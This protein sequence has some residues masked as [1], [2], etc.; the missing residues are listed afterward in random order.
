VGSDVEE[1][2]M[3]DHNLRSSKTFQ[4]AVLILS[5]RK[6]KSLSLEAQSQLLLLFLDKPSSDY[7][8]SRSSQAIAFNKIQDACK[9]G[10][11]TEASRK[12]KCSVR[13]V[14]EHLAFLLVLRKQVEKEKEVQEASDRTTHSSSLS[15]GVPKANNL[16]RAFRK[17][18]EAYDKPLKL[19]VQAE[20]EAENIVLCTPSLRLQLTGPRQQDH[21]HGQNFQSRNR[22]A[23]FLNAGTL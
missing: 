13:F 10:W 7:F 8:K 23:L 1:V 3:W 2:V 16:K 18:W 22:T 19:C 20:R 4:R 6:F 14:A 17:L 5:G 9:S 15:K 12:K 11:K 21:A